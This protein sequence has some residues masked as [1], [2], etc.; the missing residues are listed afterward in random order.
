MELI[1]LDLRRKYRLGKLVA[2][3]GVFD[4]LHLAHQKLIKRVVE[5]AKEQKL[6]SAVITFDPHSD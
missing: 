3:L 2:A 4:G 1:R 5:L 6:K